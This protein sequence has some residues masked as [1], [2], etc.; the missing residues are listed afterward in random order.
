MEEALYNAR[1][2]L[3][4]ADHLIN[5][6]LKY[7]RTVDVLK[8]VVQRLI[9]AMDFGMEALLIQAKSQGKLETVPTL[10]RIKVDNM[11]ELFADN[12]ET[13]DFVKFYQFLKK[14]DKAEFSRALEFRRHVTMTASL[15]TGQK[16]E[17]NIDIITDYNKK[18]IEFVVMAEKMIRGEPEI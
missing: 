18:V 1:A 6:S 3:K 4:R 11:K 10:P 13:L 12:E 2:E 17:I 5:V 16:V 8:H 9:S 15:D 7:T 14:I